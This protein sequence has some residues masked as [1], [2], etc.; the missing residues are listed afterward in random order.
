MKRYLSHKIIVNGKQMPGLSIVT[1]NDDNTIETIPYTEEV[2]STVYVNGSVIIE[3]NPE[4]NQIISVSI[5][6]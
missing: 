5:N 4:N 6:N 2:H 1:I 3:T